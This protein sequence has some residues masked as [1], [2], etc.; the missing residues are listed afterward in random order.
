MLA[1][2][3]LAGTVTGT[4]MLKEKR[5]RIA[6]D[7]SSVVVYVDGLREPAP[8]RLVAIEMKKKTFI[9]H[10]VVIP[11]GSSVSFPN[12]DPIFH[13][14]F[15][16]SDP[17]RFDLG[18]YKRSDGKAHTFTKPGV[19]KVYCNIHPQMSAIV[20]V[21]DNP[22]YALAQRDGRFRLEGVPAGKHTITAWHEKAREPQTVEVTVPAEAEVEVSLELDSS[23][24]KRRKHKRKDGSDYSDKY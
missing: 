7:H 11:V 4:A 3:A 10:L 19:V 6:K 2:Q 17:N 12:R 14:V 9:P 24:F 1:S 22:Y 18:L 23:R 13:N 15:S 5:G 20:V 16:V 21:R 8:P